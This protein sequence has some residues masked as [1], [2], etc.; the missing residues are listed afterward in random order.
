MKILHIISEKDLNQLKKT[1]VCR[2]ESL[3]KDGFI[4]FS[5]FNQISRVANSH[6]NGRKDMKLAVVDLTDEVKEKVVFEDLYDMDE[7]FPHLYSELKFDWVS[8]IEDMDIENDEFKIS[9]SAVKTCTEKCYELKNG[10][11]L[12]IR[13][14]VESDA[15][16]L[17]KYVQNVAGESDNLTF[18]AEEFKM[19][20]EM[21]RNFIKNSC[22]SRG[23]YFFN[24]YIDGKTVTN[25]S[26]R[27]SD[28]KR[29]S[30]KSNLG[31]SVLKEFWGQGCA[32]AMLDYM[33]EF[34]KR[35]ANTSKINLQVRTDNSAA[36]RLYE[37]KGFKIEGKDTM[38]MKISDDYFDC[39]YMGLIL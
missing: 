33:I 15:L 16:D 13:H 39:L 14:A 32:S 23:I 25:M 1:G 22:K 34:L 26:L 7:K 6:Y 4:H 19:T 20:E 37:K 21:E 28:R 29:L 10:Q 2:P 9:E 5:C 12:K 11:I 24:G 35:R 27:S 38:S 18:G 36:I 31:I 3:E 8:S 17:L 30:H